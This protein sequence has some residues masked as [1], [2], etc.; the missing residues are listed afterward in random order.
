VFPESREQ[1]DG[2]GALY[3]LYKA[4]YTYHAVDSPCE[5]QA[6]LSGLGFA[7]G[8]EGFRL[9]VRAK[10]ALLVYC[11]LFTNHGSFRLFLKIHT[12]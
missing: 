3:K 2:H 10:L 8:F 12:P 4:R 5:C 11:S 7:S 1:R 9:P 6:A